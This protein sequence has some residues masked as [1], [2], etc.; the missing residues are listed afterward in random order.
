MGPATG[1]TIR[2]VGRAKM[3]KGRVWINTCL[4]S[5]HGGLKD[6]L[7]SG[8]H[9]PQ[10]EGTTKAWGHHPQ[11]ATLKKEELLEICKK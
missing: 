3:I 8:S 6:S 11:S 2:A 10:R 9:V 1:P 4:G 7:H 5:Y